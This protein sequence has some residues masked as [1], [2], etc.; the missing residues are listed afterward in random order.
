MREQA[1]LQQSRGTVFVIR[2]RLEFGGESGPA[3]REEVILCEFLKRGCCRAVP[4][5]HLSLG[6]RGFVGGLNLFGGP[7]VRLLGALPDGCPIP[8]EPVPP[9]VT[10]LV[11]RHSYALAGPAPSLLVICLIRSPVMA[12]HPGFPAR[13]SRRMTLVAWSR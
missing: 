3:K 7:L 1:I 8:G 12:C 2:E 5:P 10:A 6:E 11:D 4:K 13:N 9:D